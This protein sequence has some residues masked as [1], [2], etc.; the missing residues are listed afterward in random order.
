MV[1]MLLKV[2]GFK[3]WFVFLVFFIGVNIGCG[4]WLY[5]D[6]EFNGLVWLF[7]DKDFFVFIFGDIDCVLV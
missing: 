3:F 4:I 5:L 1:D 6:W 7:W 2:V